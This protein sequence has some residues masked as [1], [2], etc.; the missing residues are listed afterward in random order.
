MITLSHISIRFG[1]HALFD[2]ITAT[3]GTRDRVGLVGKNGAGKSSLLKLIARQQRPD[4]GEITTPNGYTIAYLPQDM[5]TRKGFSVY[6]E[7]ASHAFA[8]HRYLDTRLHEISDEL[9]SRTDY[10]SDGYAKLLHEL[11][12]VNDEFLRIG[13]TTMRAEIET[14]MSG[15][16]FSTTDMDRLCDEFS[17]GWQMR[18]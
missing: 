10:E 8:R 4:E 1:G 13:G 2:D 5:V 12:D 14:V 9:S 6:D 3:I 7:I 11:S 15:L 18:I 17:G 16:G